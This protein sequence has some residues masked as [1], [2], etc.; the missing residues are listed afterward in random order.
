MVAARAS[1][2]DAGH[3]ESLA[4]ALGHRVRTVLRGYEHP[5]VL[6]A[7]AGTGYYLRQVLQALPGTTAPSAVALDISRYAMR[8]TAKVASTVA[9]S[10]AGRPIPFCIRF[11]PPSTKALTPAAPNEL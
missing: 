10:E 2:L 4:E 5:S 3:Y 7:G 11:A 6:D 8:R 1:F 9:L